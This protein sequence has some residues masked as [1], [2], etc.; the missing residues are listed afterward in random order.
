VVQRR[1]QLMAHVRQEFALVLG[2][3]RKLLGLFFQRLLGLLHF[4]VLRFYLGLLF[5]EQLGFFFQFRIG[6]LQLKLLALK[7]FGERLAL[8]QQLFGTHRRRDGVQNDSDRLREL[9][10]KREVN[11]AESSERRQLNRG[12]HVSFEQNRQNDDAGRGA[13]AEAG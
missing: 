12:L 13:A 9:V 10:E 7:L 1:A 8:L 2:G 6:L 4:L 3:E 11:I 5:G